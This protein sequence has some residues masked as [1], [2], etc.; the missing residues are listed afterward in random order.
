MIAA[1]NITNTAMYQLKIIFPIIQEKITRQIMETIFEALMPIKYGKVI[2]VFFL[3]I[4]KSLVSN[5]SVM[6]KIN[7]E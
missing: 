3:S 2:S 6:E 7:R 4:S 5:G 1:V